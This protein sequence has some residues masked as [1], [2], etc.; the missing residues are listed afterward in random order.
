MG[1]QRFGPETE[2]AFRREVVLS[3]RPLGSLYER[4]RLMY[5]SRMALAATDVF[6][7]AAAFFFSSSFFFFSASGSAP[8]AGTARM[9]I[10]VLPSGTS[11]ELED[12][13]MI[14]PSSNIESSNSPAV[15]SSGAW[16]GFF[17][18]GGGVGRS[19]GGE[20]SSWTPKVSGP[21]LMTSS[22]FNS[23]SSLTGLSFKK[24]PLVLPKSR[25]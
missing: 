6:P 23:I 11:L 3:E 7:E 16:T 12:L 21:T 14:G 4:G 9:S 19:I 13:E 17:V 25:K 8:G 18:G 22:F 24:V 2:K 5:L 10:T 15:S 20:T 1:L